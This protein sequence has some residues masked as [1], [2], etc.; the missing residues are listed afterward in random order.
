[1]S[2]FST[3]LSS[4]VLLPLVSPFPLRIISR[5]RLLSMCTDC[6]P[7]LGFSLLWPV[8]DMFYSNCFD[9]VSHCIFVG[10]I[11]VRD[12]AR[13]H[14]AAL[15]SPPESEVGRKRLLIASPHDLN[16]KEAVQFIAEKRPELKNRL[17]DADKAPKFSLDRIPLDLERVQ[18][19]TGVKVNSYISWQNTILDTVDSLLELEKSWVSKG[20]TVTIPMPV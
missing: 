8:R 2:Q 4:L 9:D 17:I 16:Y 7:R 14:I 13:A 6:S 11:D 12:L 10:Y 18:A 3:R 15:I 1:M 19:V 5:C 20:F